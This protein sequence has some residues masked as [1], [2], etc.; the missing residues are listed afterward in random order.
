[1]TPAVR[2]TLIAELLLL[3]AA[4]VYVAA[5]IALAYSGQCGGFMPFLTAPTPCTRLEYVWSGLQLLLAVF[6]LELWPFILPVVLAPLLVA[7]WLDRRSG[8]IPE[9]T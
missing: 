9:Q 7:W 3:A 1:M 5:E 6:F 2:R 4:L 8:R